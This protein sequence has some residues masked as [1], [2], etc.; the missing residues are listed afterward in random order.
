VNAYDGSHP[1]R[2][3]TGYAMVRRDTSAGELSVSLRSVNHRGLDLH[4]YQPPELAAYE[5]A[6]RAILKQNIARGHVEVRISL[7]RKQ[8]EATGYNHQL[9]GHYVA[10]F[11]QAC[12]E[13]GLESKPDLNALFALPGVL[14]TS[15]ERQLLDSSLEAEILK[16]VTACVKELNAH[17]EREG[18]GLCAG[19]EQEIREI[20]THTEAIAAIRKEALTYFRQRLQERLSELLA[21]ALSEARLAE[22]AAVLAD[23]S[24]VEEELTRLRVHTKELRNILASGGETGKRLEFLLQE[25]NRET[26]TIL[27]KTSGV[28]EVGLTIT[29][30]GLALKAKI[31]RIREQALNLE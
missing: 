31:E 18:Q 23:R 16:A 4:F 20:E 19:I 15:I 6:I 12:A 28:G 25:M 13:F 14:E 30:L 24:D 3:M 29:R 9:L 11:R 22:E 10:L 7:N 1:V 27:S 26:N 2:S 8:A 21:N 5:S 17:R